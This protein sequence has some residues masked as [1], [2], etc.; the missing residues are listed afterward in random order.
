[1]TVSSCSSTSL[2]SSFLYGTSSSEFYDSTSSTSII[3]D[4]ISDQTDKADDQQMQAADLVLEY[5]Q[6]NHSESL[7]FYV[8]LCALA[9]GVF[10]SKTTCSAAEINS[11]VCYH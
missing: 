1:M 10:I 5:W 2:S 6:N 4:S 9:G 11:G 8:E 3:P 7:P